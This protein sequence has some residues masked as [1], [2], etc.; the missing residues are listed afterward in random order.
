MKAQV[1]DRLVADGDPARTGV[2][3]GLLH[4]DGSPPYIVRWQSSGHVAMVSP[5]QF[6]R[7]V[8]APPV[9]QDD[10]PADPGLSRL[11]AG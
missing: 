5:G 4:E 3:I 2:I 11:P 10:Q 1:G 9:S 6:A 8:R 7:V